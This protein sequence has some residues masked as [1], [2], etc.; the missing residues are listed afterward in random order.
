MKRILVLLP[1]AALAIAGCGGDTCNSAIVP[2]SNVTNGCA[3]VAANQPLTISLQTCP[4][5]ADRNVACTA[6]LHD[7]QSG[8]FLL[9]SVAQECQSDCPAGCSISPTS[10]QVSGLAP[11][12]YH[13]LYNTGGG[14]SQVDINVV[15]GGLTSCSL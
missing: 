5:C 14:T 15:S 7:V 11:G 3:N 4:T 13:V 8:S 1:T 12:T 6:D 10:C 2:V 9:D